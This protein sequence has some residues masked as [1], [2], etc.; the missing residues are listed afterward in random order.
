MKFVRFKRRRNR[1]EWISVKEGLPEAYDFVLIAAMNKGTDEPKP[2]SIG[3]LDCH[4]E[5]EFLGAPFGSCG[6]GAWVDI[7]YCICSWHVTHWMPLPKL[8]ICHE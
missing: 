3:R 2:I 5:W 6:E 7:E 8:P 4:K 1:M